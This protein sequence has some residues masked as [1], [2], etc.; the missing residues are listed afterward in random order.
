MSERD[1]S[2]TYHLPRTA[3]KISGTVTE[4]TDLRT[5]ERVSVATSEISLATEADPASYYRID[6]EGSK[7]V[8][9]SFALELREDGRLVSTEAK[10]VGQLG[11]VIKNVFGFVTTVVGVVGK[12]VGAVPMAAPGGLAGDDEDEPTGDPVLERYAKK[13]PELARLRRD[14]TAAIHDA[15]AKI[16]AL[17]RS[18]LDADA[19]ERKKIAARV[20]ALHGSLERL[21]TEAAR[22]DEHFSAWK[23]S[24]ENATS[25]A[26]ELTFDLDDLPTR[27]QVESWGD[28]LPTQE[29]LGSFWPAYETFQLVLARDGDPPKAS[30]VSVSLDESCRGIVYRMA[31]PLEMS[32]YVVRGGKLKLAKRTTAQVFDRRSRL[33]F[34]ELGESKWTEKSAEIAFHDS[35]ALKKLSN[36]K[37]SEAAAATGT[38]KEL[39][40]EVL[41]SLEQANKIIDERQKLALQNVE[42][43]IAE[44]EQRK[45][46]LQAEIA[47]DDVLASR[48]KNA[49]L[50][51]IKK[52]IELL[53]SRKQLGDAARELEVSQAA[54]D[55]EMSTELLKLQLELEKAQIERLKVEAQLR[56]LEKKSEE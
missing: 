37:A 23:A 18:L 36:S 35:G 8:K 47:V 14:T 2:V 27:Q 16:V 13:F 11:Q 49:E 55:V 9:S 30:D 15:L 46:L 45:K 22:L 3:V 53:K 5:G 34:I 10:S 21:R 56:E 12:L 26:V 38:L 17:E 43:R 7:L 28:T 50:E 40:A 29:Q 31:R 39:P 42:Q 48:E 41:S 54:R 24:A 32:L 51:Q 6:L 44:L 1:S 25:S 19:E 52:E 20:T 33:G 4:K